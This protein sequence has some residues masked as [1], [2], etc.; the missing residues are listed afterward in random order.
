MTIRTDETH[1]P[2]GPATTHAQRPSAAQPARIVIQYPEPAVDDGA[3]PIKRCV[4]DTVSVS[5]DVFRDGHELLR[6]VVRHTD[7]DGSTGESELERIDAHLGGVRWA[8]GFTVDRAGVWQYTI[9]AWTDQFAT[10]RDE[11]ARKVAGGQIDLS[12]ELSEGM[13][14]LQAA[15]EHSSDPAATALIEHALAELQDPGIPET[16]KHDVALGA[17]LAAT[18]ER[19]PI[20]H[21]AARLPQ[22]L[23]AQV[24][25]L[26]ARFGSW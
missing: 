9:E 8:G 19:D 13:V 22:P 24:D 25:R 1:S 5:A 3:Y 7:P 20:R 4:G 17:E 15:A 11:L 6:A 21:D 18:I 14:L 26:R 12:G 2:P 16:A 23:L 10:W